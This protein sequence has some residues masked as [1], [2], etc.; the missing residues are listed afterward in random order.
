MAYE[1]RYTDTVNKGTITVE[2]GTLNTETSLTLMGR[3]VT[4]YGQAVSENFLHLLENFASNAAPSAPVE[5]QLWYDTTA[6]VDQLKLYDGTNWS[7]SSGLKK[8]NSE[9]AV[10][11]S[12]AGDVWVNTES[13]QLYLFTGTSWT[14]VGPEFSDGLLTGTKS[15]ELVSTT[16]AMYTVLTIKVKNSTAIIIS[17]RAFIPKT[18]I[19]GFRSGIKA[20]INLSTEPLINL[21]ILKYWG[22]AEKAEGLVVSGVTVPASNFLRGDATSTTDFDMRIKNDA[23]INIGVAGQLSIG[24]ESNSG[25]L[26]H[27]TSGAAIDIRLRN[28]NVIP[29]IMRIDS[30]GL[31]GINNAAPD[32]ALDVNGNVKISPLVDDNTT[33]VLLV[34]STTNSQNVSTGSIITKGGIAVAKS[35]HIGGTLVISGAVTSTNIAPDSSLSRN[36][37]TTALRYAEMHAQTFFGNIQGNVSGTVSGRAGSADKL[38]SATTFSAAGDIEHTSFAFDGQSG[39]TSKSFDIRIANS[40]ISNKDPIYQVDDADEILINKIVGTTGVHRVTKRNLLKSIPLMPAGSI[41]AFGGQEAPHGWLLCTGEEVAK[42]DWTILWTIIGHNFKDPALLSDNGVG[43]FALPDMRGRLPLGVDNAGG[44]PANRVTDVAASEIGGN[45][46]TDSTTLAVSNL[47]DHEHT[48]AGESGTQY[49]GIRTA[50]GQP[51]D[52]DAITLSVEPGTGGTQ[53]IASS[54]GIKTSDALGQSLDIMNPYLAV[55]YII[56]TGT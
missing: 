17:D 25:V 52:G 48:L 47:P 7:A 40:F 2:D 41:I 9:P 29:T 51:V 1:I 28:G 39:G 49:Y 32:E 11:N 18:L 19:T 8:S 34:E 53:G 31:V 45:A 16:D 13:Q 5:G 4:S 38:A 21:E 46:G 44:P 37:G 14:L 56:Y 33:G 3:N 35:A 30:A 36:I 6:G 12:I 42:A 43:T 23:G 26:Q 54:G 20:G 15:E 27:N 22:I 50:S 10:A 55:N 24:V